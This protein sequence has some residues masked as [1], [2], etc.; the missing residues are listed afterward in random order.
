MKKSMMERILDFLNYI[1]QN[2]YDF[3][4]EAEAK[5]GTMNTF[6][7]DYNRTHT[8]AIATNSEGIIVLQDDANK[9]ALELR[10]YVPIAP[11]T[12]IAHLF[13]R[14]RVYKTEYS[15]RLNDNGIIREL[16]N[17]GCKIGLN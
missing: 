3:F 6:I 7:S 9:W 1:K 10:L 13:G 12:D 5:P 2:G 14:N 11:P 15:Y 17:N 4:I 8:P 16:F